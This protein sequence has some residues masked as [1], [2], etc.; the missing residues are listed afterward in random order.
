MATYSDSFT[1]SAS[2]ALAT[3]NS[4]WVFVDGDGA[5]Y[6]GIVSTGTAAGVLFTGASAKN[7][8]RY[9][10][11]VGADQ[12]SEFVVVNCGVSFDP[13]LLAILVLRSSTDTSPNHDH[14]RLEIEDG[15]AS[16]ASHNF[17]IYKVTNGTAVQIGS[18]FTATLANGDA[19]RFQATGTTTT[20]LVTKVN[21]TQVD[22]RTDSSSA[23]TSGQV[24]IGGARPGGMRMASWTGGDLAAASAIGAAANYYS[25]IIG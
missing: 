18:T 14:Y 11:T 4:T 20:T 13:T 12:F 15:P 1:G 10:D 19:V 6:Y 25:S 5:A 17:L 9:N 3:Y 21:G 7:I 8:F 23:F 2:T 16:G 24:G 22:S